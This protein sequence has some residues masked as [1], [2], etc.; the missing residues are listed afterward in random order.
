MQELVRDSSNEC[1]IGV[2]AWNVQSGGFSHYDP[3]LECPERIGLIKATLQDN[4]A[5]G[6][7]T[8]MIIDAYRWPTLY[9]GNEGIAS[10]FGFKHAGHSY[11]KDSTLKGDGENIATVLLSNEEVESV[12]PLDLG[13]RQ[14]LRAVINV[15]GRCVQLF[16][17]YLDHTSEQRR[18]G[19]VSAIVGAIVSE[20]RRSD[21]VDAIP[22]VVFADFNTSFPFIT[23]ENIRAKSYEMLLT[24][25]LGRLPFLPKEQK[26]IL[27]EIRSP[28]ALDELIEVGF[29]PTDV[30]AT[31]T[32][33]LRLL[34][35]R[36][37]LVGFDGIY[38]NKA[39]EVQESYVVRRSPSDHD[40]VLAKLAV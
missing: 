25:V 30:S 34:N 11:L 15:G 24:H 16:G 29:V 33:S 12:G 26:G 40:M 19:Q 7:S 10:Q 21:K 23:R 14:G 39:V 8:Y 6:F 13:D 17:A 37:P 20:V 35:Y 2:G 22:T 31:P 27:R 9:K 5:A 38:V 28:Y 18:A 36:I 1:E 3:E 4:V 32:T